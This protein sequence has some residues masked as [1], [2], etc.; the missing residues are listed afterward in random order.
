MDEILE[1]FVALREGLDEILEG[2]VALREGLDEILEGFVA[3][4]KSWMTSW[5]PCARATKPGWSRRSLAASRQGSN[6]VMI[7]WKQAARAS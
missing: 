3:A 1:G 7:V 4:E 5:S 2:F 6:D